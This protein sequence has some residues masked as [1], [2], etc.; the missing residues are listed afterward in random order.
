MKILKLAATYCT[1]IIVTLALA[2]LT[3]IS[4]GLFPPTYRP[5]DPLTGWTAARPT[6]AMQRESCV[7]Y[8][9]GDVHSFQRNEDGART[10]YSSTQ[11]ESDNE[12]FKIAVAGDSQTEL[13][14]PN[15]QTHFGVLEQE[16]AA[17]G[18]HAATFSMAAGKYSPLQAYIAVRELAERYSA[19]AIVLNIYTGNDIYD[20]LRIDDRPYFT[21][22][23]DGSY[24]IAAPIW[25]QEDPPDAPP[26]SRV[27]FAL[28]EIGKRT[29]IWNAVVRIRYLYATAADYDA[30][31]DS[32]VLYMNDLRKTAS[33]DVGY[34][35]A[36]AAQMLNQQLFF[37]RFPGSSDAALDRVK[38]LLE[39]IKEENPNRFL[40][41]SALPSYQLVSQTD[42]DEVLL[43]AFDRLPL[44]YEDS[45]RAELRYYQEL[46]TMASD[47]G[48][49]FVDSLSALRQ[50]Q[51]TER[52]FNDFDF[53]YLPV[54]SAIIG[55]AQADVVSAQL[56]P[57]SAP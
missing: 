48:W 50:Y 19:D 56:M 32:V 21:P 53:H 9:T 2:D 6:G 34:S 17:R 57:N 10:R 25:F 44:S 26:R 1:I 18:V 36:L 7:E 55:K 3:L 23:G 20:M 30:G 16:L 37:Y 47:T 42:A 31:I 38:A 51:G 46:E 11:L 39:M 49:H 29:G 40:I 13:C 28:K 22:S 43:A 41:L 45:I 8:S 14:A 12:L 27:L 15:S 35:A 4:L 5:G 24:S 33:N 52:L 54:A